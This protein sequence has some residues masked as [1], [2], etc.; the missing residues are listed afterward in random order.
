MQSNIFS[1]LIVGQNVITLPQV[2]STN[3]YLKNELSKSTPLPE[4]TVIMAVDQVAG[5]GQVGSTW[6]S[7]AGKNLTFSV[8]FHPS[9]LFPPQQFYL[10]VAIC[11]AVV[12]WLATRINHKITIK[13]PNDIFIEDKKIA[14]ILIE[15]ILKGNEWKS[16]V[17]GIG[18][19]VNQTAFPPSLAQRV[20]SM[21]EFLHDDCNI[22]EILTE[23]CSFIQ[24][25]YVQLK[26][27][28]SAFQMAEYKHY[29]YRMGQR[30]QYE[31]S[32]IAVDGIICG[33]TEEGRLLVDFDGHVTDFGIKEIAFVFS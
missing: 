13:W 24:H 25:E 17:V 10:T 27:G 4:G 31:V 3:D 2:S 18:I 32:G 5:R 7:E 11:L 33:V 16:A 28:K 26:A 22:Q 15:N 20:C 12:K 21:K 29:L 19:N 1:G 23:L 6:Y 8:L 9:F 14:G 30:M